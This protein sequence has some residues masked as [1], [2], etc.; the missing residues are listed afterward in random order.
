MK[1]IF[2][3]PF[4]NVRD[5]FCALQIR[6]AAFSGKHQKAKRVTGFCG[7]GPASANKGGRRDI[8]EHTFGA[9]VP[10]EQVGFVFKITSAETCARTVGGGRQRKELAFE[11]LGR[12]YKVHA[13]AQCRAQGISC[14]QQH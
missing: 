9:H 11:L 2:W 12:I 8:G 13:S 10:P 4:L 6:A 3:E 14:R 7:F 1:R 5:M